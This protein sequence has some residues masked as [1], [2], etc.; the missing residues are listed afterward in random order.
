[1]G[2][3]GFFRAGGLLVGTHAFIAYGNMLGVRWD[4]FDSA[5]TQDIDFAHAG[6]SISLVLAAEQS[7]DVH[8]AIE[9]LKLGFFP[10][11]TMGGNTGGAYLHPTDPEFRLDFLT[12]LGR[13]GEVPF[14]HK[15]LGVTLQPLRFMEFSLENVQQ[16]TLLCGQDALLVNIPHP[17][18]YALHKLIVAGLRTGIFASKANKDLHQAALLL[19]VL[20]EARPW[21]V[22]EA[23]ADL[24]GRGPGWVTRAT[25]GLKQL[26]KKYA[27]DAFGQWLKT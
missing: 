4:S 11:G 7:V 24:L 18:R 15:D 2:E 12:T 10:I 8:S 26:E 19:R 16:S 6:K 25:S 9:S 22:E 20:R 13:D 3:Y 27:A 5:R 1:M 14:H 17:A 21:E 23:W